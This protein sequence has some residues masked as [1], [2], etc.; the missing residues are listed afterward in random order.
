MVRMA[1]VPKND[2]NIHRRGLGGLQ[3]HEAI[4]HR[5]SDH[6]WRTCG[7]ELEQDPGVSCTQL[8]RVRTIRNVEGVSRSAGHNFNVGRLR[9]DDAR[10]GLGGRSGSVGHYQPEWIRENSPY[11]DR[12]IMGPTSICP[13]EIVVWQSTREG[14][15]CR[16]IH[17]IL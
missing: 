3:R 7:D 6:N 11:P 4:H 1:A 9:D 5:R 13:I 10:G 8:R 14:N 16:P 2:Y 15:S 12:I 17:K